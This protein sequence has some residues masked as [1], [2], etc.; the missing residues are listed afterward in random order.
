MVQIT[1]DKKYHSYPQRMAEHK[2]EEQEDKGNCLTAQREYHLT[3][4]IDL[5]PVSKTKVCCTEKD[6]KK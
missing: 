4:T 3:D 1:E 2:S 5:D 6:K